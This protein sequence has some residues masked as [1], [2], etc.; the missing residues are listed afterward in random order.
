MLTGSRLP[1]TEEAI[2]NG[3][4]SNIRN[5]LS[6]LFAVWRLETYTGPDTHNPEYSRLELAA[7]LEGILLE[8]E[9]T[10]KLHVKEAGD[11]EILYFLL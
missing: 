11:G 1:S 3:Y 10:A 8:R 2:K 9:V 5:Y 7:H 6:S 4:P